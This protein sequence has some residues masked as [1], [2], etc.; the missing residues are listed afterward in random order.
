MYPFP[1]KARENLSLV[2]DRRPCPAGML[3]SYFLSEIRFQ[4]DSLAAAGNLA[5]LLS[6]A[7]PLM[8]SVAVI[9]KVKEALWLT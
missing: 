8:T 2:L 3:A 5:R 6:I 4:Y 1:R 7:W 9:L